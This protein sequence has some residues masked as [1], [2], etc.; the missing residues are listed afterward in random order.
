M[1]R[2]LWAGGIGLALGLGGAAAA[3]Q[4]LSGAPFY[5]Q[6]RDPLTY[7]VAAVTLGVAALLAAMPPTIGTL[8]ADLL[9]ALRDN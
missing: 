1:Q 2:T 6:S 3:S 9:R 8:R 4:F 7:V 5:V